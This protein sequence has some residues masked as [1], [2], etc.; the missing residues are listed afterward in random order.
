MYVKLT[1][2]C[3]ENAINLVLFGHSDLRKKLAKFFEKWYN[4]DNKKQRNYTN[5][6]A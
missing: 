3:P 6:R 1:V 2:E 4:K 5:D